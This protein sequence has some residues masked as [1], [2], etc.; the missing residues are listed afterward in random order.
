MRIR[1]HSPVGDT[2]IPHKPPTDQSPQKRQDSYG[3]DRYVKN[4]PGVGMVYA[5]PWWAGR[6]HWL[7][8]RQRRRRGPTTDTAWSTPSPAGQ[9]HVTGYNYCK[10]RWMQCCGSGIR[11]LFDPW[12]RNTGWVKSQDSDPGYRSGMEKSRIRVKSHGS[13]TLVGWTYEAVL[14]I[15][16]GFNADPDPGF[17]WQKKNM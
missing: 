9:T 7:T 2:K 13:A 15:R 14:W 4:W 12:N 6:S 1:I 10:L 3:D 16:L 8:V 5:P 11:C 17:R